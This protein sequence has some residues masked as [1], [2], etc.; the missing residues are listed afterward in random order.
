MP[1]GYLCNPW[2]TVQAFKII[3]K[4]ELTRALR[5]PGEKQESLSRQT[6]WYLVPLSIL[7]TLVIPLAQRTFH[8]PDLW[9]GQCTGA[10]S[11]PFLHRYPE[12]Q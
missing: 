5:F 10:T 3:S 6:A 4:M 2:S 1:H 9:R 7:G 11:Y 8:L 12:V